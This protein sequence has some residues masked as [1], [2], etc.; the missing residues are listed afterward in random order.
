[1]FPLWQNKIR[2]RSITVWSSGIHSAKVDVA[3]GT[4]KSTTASVVI[5][6]KTDVDLKIG[7]LNGLAYFCGDCSFGCKS[8]GECKR[9]FGY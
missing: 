6:A 9:C 8:A 7:G 1:M 3:G 2:L 4:I 5:N